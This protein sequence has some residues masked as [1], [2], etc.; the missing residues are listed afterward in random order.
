MESKHSI[1]VALNGRHFFRVE[2]TQ[3]TEAQAVTMVQ[4]FQTRFPS[5]EGFS[6]SLTYWQA[7]G[8]TIAV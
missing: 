5:K 4:E 6:V 8:H 2:S 7:T 1:N 3:W